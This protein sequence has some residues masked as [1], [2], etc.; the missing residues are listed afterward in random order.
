MT[1]SPVC[2]APFAVLLLT[3]FAAGR[4]EGAK[5]PPAPV[6]RPERPPARRDPEAVKWLERALSHF[7][8]PRRLEEVGA[9]RFT[10]EIR[11]GVVTKSV[12]TTTFEVRGSR[13]RFDLDSKR[14]HLT[15]VADAA[16]GRGVALENDRPVPERDREP[17]VERALGYAMNDVTWVTLPY[18]AADPSVALLLG[19]DLVRD[20]RR[21]KR[22]RFTIQ[23]DR[24]A[25]LVHEDD[26]RIHGFEWR[27]H[28]MPEN[29][30][31][32]EFSCEGR[33]LFDGLALFT[34]YHQA[35]G[36]QAVFVR[37]VRVFDEVP[38]EVF[39]ALPERPDRSAKGGGRPA[40]PPARGEDGGR[41]AGW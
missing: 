11:E 1:I 40:E 5:P 3:P 15:V 25:L 29:V 23:G 28:R 20:G 30:P 19:E 36:V 2:A 27:P 41:R 38:E 12:R 4:Q 18:R 39:A 10:Y 35:G 13:I 9:L 22:L 8:G 6:E 31:D 32:F 16:D 17:V 26:A 33:A 7:L 14:G 24:F 37:D 34:E 21:S